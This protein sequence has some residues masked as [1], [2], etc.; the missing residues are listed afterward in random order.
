MQPVAFD[1]TPLAQRLEAQRKSSAGPAASPVPHAVLPEH[2]TA[3]GS[4]ASTLALEQIHVLATHVLA[5]YG[6]RPFAS[7]AITSA[8]PGEGKTTI[9]LALAQRLAQARKRVLVVDFDL[10]RCALTRE[11]LLESAR[12][13]M[14]AIADGSVHTPL[15]W[16]PTE[17]PGLCITPR[18]A[19]PNQRSLPLPDK[20]RIQ[21]V[22]AR[23]RE[24]GFE[25]VVVDCPP[26]VPVADAHV[27]G[28]AVD[29][30]V[31]V[32][33]ANAT[34]RPVVEQAVEEFGRDRFFAAVLN[35]AS[36]GRIPYFRE[37]YGYYR[38][39]PS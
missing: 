15:P 38:G 31:M 11:V 36:P 35:R 34:P 2:L 32:V 25:L 13:V 39:G 26:L 9:T 33:R 7:V 12:G 10:H 29:G 4:W 16:Y 14:E 24:Q 6:E 21:G 19:V 18:G 8:L 3:S 27:I 5:R 28:E 1:L 37:V 30:A 17:C 20:A 22:L 23:A